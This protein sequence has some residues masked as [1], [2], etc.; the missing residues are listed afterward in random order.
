MANI[1]YRS[2]LSFLCDSDIRYSPFDIRYLVVAW[3][4]VGDT[5]SSS[6]GDEPRGD[7][8]GCR[9]FLAVN[10]RSAGTGPAETSGTASATPNQRPTG[11]YPVV[12]ILRAGPLCRPIIVPR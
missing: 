3:S 6:H 8:L 1:E 11:I 5:E 10:H 4:C 2:Q 9:V 12:T 7:H